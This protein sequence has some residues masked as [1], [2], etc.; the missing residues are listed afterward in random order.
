MS[1]PLS[2][3]ENLAKTHAIL[4]GTGF[5]VLLPLGALI[6]RYGRNF[7][8]QYV[9]DPFSFSL[10]L[11]SY[12][13]FWTHTIFQL[14]F[15]GPVIFA[16]FAEGNSVHGMLPR[17]ERNAGV[18]GSIGQVLVILYV[19]QV[20]IG[21][22]IHYIKFPSLFGGR[23]PPQNYVHVVLGISILALSAY[24]VSSLIIYSTFTHDGRFDLFVIKMY[25]GLYTEWLLLGGVHPMSMVAKHAWLALVVVSIF[26]RIRID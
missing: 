10:Q 13:W 7:T 1:I 20:V 24:N 4:C 9:N 11:T 17:S 2:P 6:G 12:S 5:L 8:R 22:F 18:H 14:L 16:G 19:V 3:V 26:I 23:R 15:A 25:N 21:L